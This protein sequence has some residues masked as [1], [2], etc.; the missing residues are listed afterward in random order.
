MISRQWFLGICVSWGLSEICIVF[1]VFLAPLIFHKKACVIGR[2]SWRSQKHFLVDC[3]KRCLWIPAGAVL[4]G[5][6]S[7]PFCWWFGISQQGAPAVHHRVWLNGH[8]CRL[9]L[10][11]VHS[12]VQQSSGDML[13]NAV[14]VPCSKE[15]RGG[16][17]ALV[18]MGCHQ[19]ESGQCCSLVDLPW[20][21]GWRIGFKFSFCQWF[22]GFL[23]SRQLLSVV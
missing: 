6:V 14:V 22:S 10:C 17:H 2:S 18:W 15:Q 4:Q 12:V 23:H 13:I 7:W 8:D 1:T 9:L 3:L 19:W 20:D 16:S 21:W 11:K 5:V